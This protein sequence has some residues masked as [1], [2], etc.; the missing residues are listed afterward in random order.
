[1]RGASGRV[2]T[3]KPTKKMGE[4]VAI[5]RVKTAALLENK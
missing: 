3:P 5:A 2:N 4:S 1:M